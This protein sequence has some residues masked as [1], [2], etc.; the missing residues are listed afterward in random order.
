MGDKN[1]KDEFSLEYIPGSLI[2]NQVTSSSA[3]IAMC[4][5]QGM[6]KLLPPP[7]ARQASGRYLPI[8]LYYCNH[9]LGVSAEADYLSGLFQH[10]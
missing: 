8:C 4:L 5:V 10:A 6:N 9:T 3:K 1:V 2:S 7:T